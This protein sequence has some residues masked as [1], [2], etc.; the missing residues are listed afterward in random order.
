MFWISVDFICNV[1]KY[2]FKVMFYLDNLW[3]N[4]WS[5]WF[6]GV[7]WEGWFVVFVV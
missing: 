2:C 3:F 4:N 6:I 5:V 1:L 7:I